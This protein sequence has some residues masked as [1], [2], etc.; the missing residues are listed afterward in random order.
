MPV[1]LFV[2]MA[3]GRRLGRP[4]GGGA[5]EGV[6]RLASRGSSLGFSVTIFPLLMARL[7]S[8]CDF[9]SFIL[10]LSALLASRSFGVRSG[11]M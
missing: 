2:V 8:P 1:F 11:D 9:R 6:G 4:G 10:F 7:V 3:D 5:A